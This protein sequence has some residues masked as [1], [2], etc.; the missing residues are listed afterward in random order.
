MQDLGP[1]NI[2]I[3]VPKSAI[4]QTP[5]LPAYV[6]APSDLARYY[7]RIAGKDLP[8]TK[9]FDFGSGEPVFPHRDSILNVSS[10]AHEMGTHPLN[11]Q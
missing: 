10:P 7:D 6:L 5:S 9:L 2:T 8:Q 4:N 1:Y 11:F 3:I